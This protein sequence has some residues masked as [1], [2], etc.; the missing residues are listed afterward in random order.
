M[1]GRRYNICMVSCFFHPNMGGVENH[2][3]QLSQCLLAR[4]HKVVVITHAYGN[5]I[6]VR[7][8]T[9][10]LKVYYLPV[11]VFFKQCTVPTMFTTLPMIRDICIREQ[12]DI[13]HGHGAFSPLCHEA[14]LHARTMGIRAVFTDHSLFGFA[15]YSSINSNKFL[16]FV[17]TDVD[18]AICVSYT[19]KENTVLRAKLP[20][21][22]VSVIP[23]AV[24]TSCFTPDPS[25]RTP[26]RVTIVVISRLVYRKGMDLLAGVIPIICKRH[27]HVDFLIGGDGN[28]RVLLEQIREQHD[29]M[30]RVTLLGGLDHSQ[31]RDVLVQGDIFLNTSLT[32]AFC[33]AIVEAVSCGLQV[34]STKVGGVP[35]VLPNDM[36]CMAEPNVSSL[37]E[38]LH[39]AI[40]VQRSGQQLDAWESHQRVTDMYNWYDIAERTEKVYDRVIMSANRTYVDQIYKH[41]SRGPVAGIVYVALL[42]LLQLVYT[43]VAWIRPAKGVDV[44]PDVIDDKND[45]VIQR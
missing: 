41:Y 23:N 1:G 22:L 42:T 30:D 26:G 31:V 35:E 15:D 8:L 14:L 20:P 10:M 29:L 38:A 6:G 33:I 28:Y 12:V 24:D 18:H 17:L 4:G 5:R 44:V 25:K 39:E 43:L 27:S 16:E 40:E 13:L 34:I 32:E 2:I 45:D 36:I 21:D 11:H 19:S 3:Y 7:Y 37:A 9:S